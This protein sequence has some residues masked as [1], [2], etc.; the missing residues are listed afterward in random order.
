MSGVDGRGGVAILVL[1]VSTLSVLFTL[2]IINFHSL[3]RSGKLK[4]TYKNPSIRKHQ[5][6][7]H[8]SC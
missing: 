8:V 5:Q 1:L 2:L 4:H 3:S 7:L 6:I